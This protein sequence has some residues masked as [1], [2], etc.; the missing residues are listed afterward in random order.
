MVTKKER[1][2]NAQLFSLVVSVA[3]FALF[4]V[5]M[6][7]HYR[8]IKASQPVSAQ[9]QRIFDFG[10]LRPTLLVGGSLIIAFPLGLAMLGDTKISGLLIPLYTLCYLWVVYQFSKR[11]ASVYFGVVIDPKRGIVAFPKD[12]RN[13]GLSDYF[14]LKNLRELGDMEELE[15]SEIDKITRQAGKTIYLHGIFGS[16]GIYFSRKQK[17]DECIAAIQK[18]TRPGALMVEFETS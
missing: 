3:V 15:L 14:A 8:R 17:R 10:N 11:I 4:S 12:L 13:Y 7:I 5:F 1:E 9:G 16:R 18:N 2:Q 6:V